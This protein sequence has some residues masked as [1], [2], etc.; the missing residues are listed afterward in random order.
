[1]GPPELMSEQGTDDPDSPDRARV[2]RQA[3]RGGAARFSSDESSGS[4]DVGHDGLTPA[5][6]GESELAVV[7]R[8]GMRGSLLAQWC[9][10]SLFWG[11]QGSLTR[12]KNPEGYPLL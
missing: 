9:P 12:R 5:G 3:A 1:M 2:V 8:A 6:Q 4:V 7:G 11:K 10:L